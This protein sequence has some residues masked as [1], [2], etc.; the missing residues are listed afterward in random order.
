MKCI[1]FTVI[2]T[3]NSKFPKRYLTATSKAPAYPRVLCHINGVVQR[4]QM[5]I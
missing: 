4:Y 3:V 2:V 1:Y 5:K